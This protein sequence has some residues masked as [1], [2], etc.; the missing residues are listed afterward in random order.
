MSVSH[1][2]GARVALDNV[3]LEFPAGRMAGQIDPDGV[4]KSTL[5]GLIGGARTFQQGT[6]RAFGGDMADAAHRAAIRPRIAYMPQGLGRNLYPTLSAFENI[7]SSAT[8]VMRDIS[9]ALRQMVRV[10][11]RRRS[12]HRCP[13][14]PPTQPK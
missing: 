12:R 7:T 8:F 5:L 9:F 2:Y 11:R 4:G 14:R 1:R 10:R 13:I 3:R 6:V